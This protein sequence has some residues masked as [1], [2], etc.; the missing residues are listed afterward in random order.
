MFEELTPGI[1]MNY[2]N[3]MSSK[4]D[5]PACVRRR[6]VLKENP[7]FFE[8]HEYTEKDKAWF[9]NSLADENDTCVCEPGVPGGVWREMMSEMGPHDEW[10]QRSE[11]SR[12]DDLAYFLEEAGYDAERYQRA[13]ERRYGM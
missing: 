2:G 13:V 10:F 11:T 5:T 12:Q 8:Q 6:H 7:K 3:L 4:D 9:Y 1:R